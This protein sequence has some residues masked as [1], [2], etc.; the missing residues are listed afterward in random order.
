MNR[1]VK[2]VV[3]LILFFFLLI[4][5]LVLLVVSIDPS[6]LKPTLERE[7]ARQG[8]A[9]HFG[10][11]IDWQF[12]PDF[13]L[14]VQALSLNPADLPD[15]GQP[16]LYVDS[17]SFSVKLVP[18]FKREILVN[19]IRVTS[20]KLDLVVDKDGNG[21]WESIDGGDKAE[22][23]PEVDEA[24]AQ[25][26]LPE[27][28]IEELTLSSLSLGYTDRQ[29]GDSFIVEN[30]S[31]EASDFN[32]EG[33]PFPLSISVNAAVAELPAI[34]ADLASVLAF[35]MAGK[36]LSLNDAMLRLA[37]TNGSGK[38]LAISFNSRVNW[39]DPLNVTASLNASEFNPRKL[40]KDFELAQ[41]PTQNP[42]ALSNAAFAFDLAYSPKQIAITNIQAVLDSTHIQ[43][44]TTLSAT[45]KPR[46]PWHIESR[47]S[48]D[49]INLDDYLPPTSETATEPAAAEPQPLPLE[50][51]RSLSALLGLTFE[52]ILVMDISIK[53]IEAEVQAENGIVTIDKLNAQA[54]DGTLA[55]KGTFDATGEAA[56]LQLA[57]NVDSINVGAL[58]QH[59][60]EL[61]NLAGQA[62]T[63]V[64]VTS[65]GQT[66]QALI[67]NVV[68]EAVISSENLKVAPINL[69]QQYCK[70]LATLDKRELA[71]TDWNAFTE[72][73]PVTVKARYTADQVTLQTLDAQI[74]KLSTKASGELNLETGRFNFPIDISLAD[75]S[76]GPEACGNI[77]EKWRKRAIPLLCKGNLSNIGADTCLPDTDRIGD[78][79][80]AAAEEKVEAKKQELE[81]KVD[82]EV[83]E[84][85]DVIED[86]A[87]SKLEKELERLKKKGFFNESKKD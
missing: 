19:G 61:D 51:I 42:Q 69:E 80:K 12:Y 79:V 32:L 9:A 14:S 44:N 24:P 33:A 34:S 13:G 23:A 55:A 59:F 87:K 73:Q 11:E 67:N 54:F 58:A 15:S 50:S 48:G 28:Q 82:T 17:M 47:W 57:L 74:E 46:I 5:A 83:E 85:K 53:D 36:T 71:K 76:S 2:F 39:N 21:N 7:L 37:R 77:S 43:G 30:L 16:L 66:D 49:R 4:G 68:A 62:G 3:Y 52:E 72:L 26:T 70:L 65:H 40:M 63:E 18:L 56:K 6:R 78:M 1:I 20:A 75:F 22:P 86:K 27:L 45:E 38:T 10:G 25:G 64:R 29:S 81:K 35:D 84:K 31:V 60:A 41:I 8:I